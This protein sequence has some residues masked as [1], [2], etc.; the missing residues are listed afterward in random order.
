MFRLIKLFIVILLCLNFISVLEAQQQSPPSIKWE[1]KNSDHFKVIFPPELDSLA[2]YT[3]NFLENIYDTSSYGLGIHVRKTPIILHNTSA[4]SNAFVSWGPRRSEFFATSPPQEYTFI[5]NNNWINLLAIHEFRHLVQTEKALSKPINKLVYLF[6]GENAFRA[7]G[8]ASMPFWFWEGDAVDTE[9][10]LTNY[11]RGR[12]PSFLRTIKSNVN[13]FS[14]FSYYKHT[15]GSY[16]YKTPNEYE[17]GYLITRYIKEN[18]GVD[19]FN[20]IIDKTF[21]QSLT[22]FPFVRNL[23]KETSLNLKTLYKNSFRTLIDSTKKKQ[24]EGGRLNQRNSK[25]YSDFLYPRAYKENKIL[26]LTKGLNSLKHFAVIDKNKNVKKLFTPGLIKDQGFIALS[27]N[28]LAWIEYHKDPRWDNRVFS[29]IKILNI[30][31]KKFVLKTKKAMYSSVDLSSDGL[32]FVALENLPS[33]VGKLIVQNIASSKP[34]VNII[35]KNGVYTH[36]RFSDEKNKIIGLKT[37]DEKKEIVLIDLGNKKEKV[38]YSTY[39]NIGN[40]IKK[41]SFVF[42]NNVVAGVDNI[43]YVD[44][45]SQ[46]KFQFTNSRYGAYN[47]SLLVSV[48]KNSDLKILYNNYSPFGF[49]VHEKK[50]LSNISRQEIKNEVFKRKL[51][52][53]QTKTEYKTTRYY[54]WKNLIRPVD[55]GVYN[56][57]GDIKGIDEVSFGINSQDLM[58]N[59]VFSTGYLYDNYKKEGSGVFKLSYLGLYPIFDLSFLKT[60]KKSM[61]TIGN[62]SSEAKSY[63]VEWDE[64]ELKI[65]TK[66]PLSF[67]SSKYLTSLYL[68]SNYSL[69]RLQNVYAPFFPGSVSLNNDYINYLTNTIYYSR[70]H[71]K[72]KRNV[73]YPWGQTFLF[74]H[75]YMTKASNFSGYFFRFDSFFDFPGINNTHSLRLGFH[76]EKQTQNGYAF[77]SSVSSIIGY[78]T[79][80]LFTEVISGK[81]EYEFPVAYPHIHL[82]PFLNFQRIRYTSFINL[83]QVDGVDYNTR[84]FVR[85]QPFGFGGDLYFD[86]NFFRQP[87]VFSLG[88]RWGYILKNNNPTFDLLLSNISF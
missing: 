45:A 25:S 18:Y 4:L 41:G 35:L 47:P 59:L 29:N 70:L 71:K 19:V 44:L 75:K 55:W 72:T 52:F 38:L 85:E 62:G 77:A 14:P 49:D 33:G 9:T 15:L 60:K 84:L 10:R 46:K 58:G 69:T 64:K 50:F 78:R 79:K 88:V 40:P 28:L 57:S 2:N 17:S 22:P 67:T 61:I 36:L 48:S 5:S 43:V 66:I 8:A 65:G 74:Q 7:L 39:E 73:Y 54:K 56:Y 82:G 81:I 68:E 37:W 6:F 27:N 31:K 30:D 20:T 23:K 86:V 63:D 12:E 53:K 83:G 51:I 34:S 87:S 26:V 76:F 32:S 16:K 24:Q 1:Q 80:N 11:G 3:L 21:S 42:F 13:S